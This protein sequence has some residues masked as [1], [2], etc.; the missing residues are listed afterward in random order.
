MIE[1]VSEPSGNPELLQAILSGR[2][3]NAILVRLTAERE[4]ERAAEREARLEAEQMAERARLAEFLRPVRSVG[5][6][7]DPPLSAVKEGGG[8]TVSIRRIQTSRNSFDIFMAGTPDI[9]RGTLQ[10][11]D[12]PDTSFYSNRPYIVRGESGESCLVTFD[13]VLGKRFSLTLN[14]PNGESWVFPEIKF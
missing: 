2:P 12:V 13:R 6:D 8:Q 7:F 10:N 1:T 14:G 4:V 5:L 11:L 9:S 3:D